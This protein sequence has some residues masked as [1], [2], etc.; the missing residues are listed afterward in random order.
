ME[1]ILCEGWFRKGMQLYASCVDCTVPYLTEV[2][3]TN[4]YDH[5][6]DME[7]SGV[8]GCLNCLDESPQI[9][10]DFVSRN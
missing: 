3:V 5:V 4:H 7:E 10:I 8:D 9:D 1:D 6:G 2:T